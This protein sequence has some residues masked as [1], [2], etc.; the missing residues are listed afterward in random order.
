MTSRKMKVTCGLTPMV[1][2]GYL[3]AL[4]GL[5]LDR[6]QGPPGESTQVSV[7]TTTT[8]GPGVPASVT[9]TVDGN[10]TYP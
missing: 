8:V 5:M 6:F 1:M 9:E 7:G 4:H 2:V 3:K 10:Q